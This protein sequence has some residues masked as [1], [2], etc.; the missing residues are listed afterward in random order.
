VASARLSKGDGVAALSGISVA[1]AHRRKG[2]G[3]L[4]T[5]IATRA[6]LA[7]GNRLVW[8]SVDE[9]NAAAVSLYRSL[10]YEPSFQ[11]AHWVASAGRGG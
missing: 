2:Y 5:A 10:G 3:T 7:T 4:V 1:T 8:L 6:G 11:W 9:S